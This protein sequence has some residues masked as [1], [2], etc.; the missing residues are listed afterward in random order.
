[1]KELIRIASVLATVKNRPTRSKIND[2]IEKPIQIKKNPNEL[3][4]PPIKRHFLSPILS[5]RTAE[6]NGKVISTKLKIFEK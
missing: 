5:A 2:F 1:M 4:I 3:V 6:R